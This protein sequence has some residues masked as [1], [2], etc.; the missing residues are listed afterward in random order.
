MFTE[1]DTMINIIGKLKYQSNLSEQEKALADHI[2]KHKE[3]VIYMNAEQLVDEADASLS[4]LYRL[5][6]KL[7]ISGFS[8]FKTILAS[9]INQELSQHKN[10][11]YNKP[12]SK[13]DNLFDL[14][15]NLGNLYRQS[16]D[17]TLSLIDFK[18]LKEC[19]NKIKNARNIFLITTHLNVSI[20]ET[21]SMHLREIGINIHVLKETDQQRLLCS[22]SRKGDVAIIL[23]Y[24]GAS[25]YVQEC[26]IE[27]YRNKADIIL[28]SS[29]HNSKFRN[30]ATH[31]LLLCS[32]E[33]KV[34][35]ITT[36]SSYISAQFI[37]DLL[38]S[39]LYQENYEYNFNNR[40]KHYMIKE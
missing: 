17:Q 11:D 31:Q 40:K 10:V 35:K 36:F 14:T 21:F 38:Y 4:T 5:C 34:Q 18:E 30:Y 33:D 24:S 9:E 2:L 19:A 15:S 29:N 23:S 3:M 25:P 7:K 39:L 1:G 37:F 13:D 32:E 26:I 6:R 28:V 12:F 8:Q 20:A 16:I 22:L 27:L